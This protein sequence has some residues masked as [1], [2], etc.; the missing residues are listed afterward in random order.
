MTE[1]G[2]QVEERPGHSYRNIVRAGFEPAYVRPNYLSPQCRVRRTGEFCATTGRSGKSVEQ[3]G[4][5][6]LGNDHVLGHPGR[7][8]RSSGNQ[9][10][11]QSG[12]VVAMRAVCEAGRE[13]PFAAGL[14]LL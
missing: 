10:R 13:S 3:V 11:S 5:C 2:E 6:W 8:W 9:G 4:V 12:R 1:T 14:L 7:L